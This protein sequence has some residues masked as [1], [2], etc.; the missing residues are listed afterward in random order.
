MR[1]L[2]FAATMTLVLTVGTMAVMTVHPQPA[3]ACAGNGC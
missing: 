3:L 1:K 2:I